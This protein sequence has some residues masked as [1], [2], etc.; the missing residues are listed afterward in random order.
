MST[1]PRAESSRWRSFNF[2]PGRPIDLLDQWNIVLTHNIGHISDKSLHVYHLDR[3]E[4]F[5][6][7]LN[8]CFQYVLHPVDRMCIDQYSG[9][10]ASSS[11]QTFNVIYSRLTLI[12]HACLLQIYVHS[13]S[14]TSLIT[15]NT[16][17]NNNDGFCFQKYARWEDHR[18]LT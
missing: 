17:I 13:S 18:H 8:L 16:L 14:D 12:L 1:K 2:I 7:W 3:H 15:R 5:I 10:V 4:V 9:I 6:S 11:I